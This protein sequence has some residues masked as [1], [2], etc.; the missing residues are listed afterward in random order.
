MVEFRV[1]DNGLNVFFRLKFKRNRRNVV[2]CFMSVCVSGK[3]AEVLQQEGGDKERE[4]G[5][6]EAPPPLSR[7]CP[8]SG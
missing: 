7:H 8:N 2:M 4:G 5:A 6:K 1:I 3:D